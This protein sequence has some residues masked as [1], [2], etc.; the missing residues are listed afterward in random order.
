[1][2]R[3]WAA[4]ALPPDGPDQLTALGAEVVTALSIPATTAMA[5][6]GVVDAR[7]PFAKVADAAAL[8]WVVA[9]TLPSTPAAR[10]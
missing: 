4:G 8:P 2:R 5:A 10:S 9:V 1:M 3:R 7:G 6:V